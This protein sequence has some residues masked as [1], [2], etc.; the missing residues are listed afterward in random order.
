MIP[1]VSFVCFHRMPAYPEKWPQRQD[2]PLLPLFFPA[3]VIS[4][5]LSGG[6]Q[7]ALFRRENMCSTLHI[8]CEVRAKFVFSTRILECTVRSKKRGSNG[9]IWLKNRF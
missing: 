6:I 3:D 1:A 2:T 9:V 4:T 7:Y 5:H 8:F